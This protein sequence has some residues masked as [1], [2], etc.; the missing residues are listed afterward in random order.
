MQ[1]YFLKLEFFG[2]ILTDLKTQEVWELNLDTAFYMF[3]YKY[4]KNKESVNIVLKEVLKK[5]L[6]DISYEVFDFCNE[7]SCNYTLLDLQAEHSNDLVL[8][9]K[10]VKAI[11]DACI[12]QD[13]FSF[14]NEVTIYPTTNCQLNC[15]FCFI[16]DCAKGFENKLTLPDWK[17]IIK[18]C[19]VNGTNSF[20]I[21]GGEPFLYRDILG[22]LQEI[23]KNSI[24]AT[25]TT[26]GIYMSDDVFHFITNSEHLTPVYSIQAL[27]EKNRDLMGISPKESI[28]NLKKFID[29]GKKCR[30]NSVLLDQTFEEICEII[31]FCVTNEIKRYSIGYYMET[32]N[33]IRCA[34]KNTLS[35]AKDWQLKINE[36]LEEKDYAN[37]IAVRIEGCML[38]SAYHEEFNENIIK[39]EYDRL[40]YGCECGNTKLEIMPNGD[41]FAC[42]AFNGTQLKD[43]VQSYSGIKDLWNNSPMMSDFRKLKN[44]QVQKEC[45][46]CNLAIFCKGVCP[47]RKHKRTGSIFLGRDDACEVI[48]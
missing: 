6:L 39:T 41:V 17:N 26:N 20:S 30:I 1:N 4:L 48:L 29:V 11:Y 42:I 8:V 19:V 36:Y 40:S 43:N 31:D 9:V 2:G 23:D 25:I 27:T 47:Y 10:C 38:Y 35:N 37:K 15:N 5:E 28:S 44:M 14:P 16:S 24:R 21:L 12:I 45:L 3:V 7:Y 46:R 34:E 18:E 13:Y 22:L 32:H 33:K